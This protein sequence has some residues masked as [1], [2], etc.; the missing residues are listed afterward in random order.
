MCCLPGMLLGTCARHLL[1]R[2]VPM[3]RTAPRTAAVHSAKVFSCRKHV[4]F[5]SLH[6]ELRLNDRARFRHAGDLTYADTFD[7]DAQPQGSPDSGSAA[8]GA[9]WDAWGRLT[10]SLFAQVPQPASRSADRHQRRTPTPCPV[11]SGSQR[12]V[13]LA[14]INYAI[15]GN[16]EIDT[17]SCAFFR[18]CTP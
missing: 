17:L 15:R 1:H 5:G 18:H 7:Q 16:A 10:S 8:S 9:K 2:P 13:L 14:A 3:A 11:D 6:A 4:S 12:T